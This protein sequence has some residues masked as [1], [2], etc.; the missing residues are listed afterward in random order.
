MPVSVLRMRLAECLDCVFTEK[1]PIVG[2]EV[3]LRISPEGYRHHNSIYPHI[4]STLSSGCTGDMRLPLWDL[5][6]PLQ[7]LC[8]GD[9]S[10]WVGMRRY[11]AVLR[12]R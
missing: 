2:I 7:A 5:R 1:G 11:I 8:G 6:H 9:G 4:I 3:L 10:S 12:I